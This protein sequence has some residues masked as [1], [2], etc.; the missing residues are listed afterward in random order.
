MQ[1]GHLLSPTFGKDYSGSAHPLSSLPSNQI[2]L[3]PSNAATNPLAPLIKQGPYE[4]SAEETEVLRVGL[5][6][7]ILTYE[8]SGHKGYSASN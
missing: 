1:T 2:L 5:F 7:D 6:I 8:F 3:A 4:P